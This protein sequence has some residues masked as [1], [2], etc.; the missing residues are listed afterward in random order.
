[1][2]EKKYLAFDLGAES[3]RAVIGF[4]NGKSLRLEVLH[5]FKNEPQMLG[6]TLYWDILSLFKEMKNSLK[7]FKS[8]Y[9]NNLESIGVDTWG[10]DFGLIGKDGNLLSNPV[11]YRD[12]RTNGILKEAFKQVSKYEIYKK[13]GIQVMQINTLYQLLSLVITDSPLL[14]VS[15]KFLMIPDLFNYFFT[16]EKL[17]EWTDATTTQMF[18]PDKKTWAKDLLRKMKIPTHIMPDVIFPGIKIGNLLKSISNETSLTNVK[19]C[20]PASHDT[21][22]AVVSVPSTYNENWAYLSSGTWSLLGVEIKEPIINKESYELNFTNEGG[23]FGTYRFLKN[24]MGLWLLQRCR[25]EWQE[26][27]SEE[28]SYKKLVNLAKKAKRLRS[29]IDPNHDSFLNPPNMT[30]A[31][32]NYCNYTNQPVPYDMALVVRCIFESLSFTY[33][34]VIDDLNK[35]TKRKIRVLHIVGGGVQ[36]KLLCQFT[37]NAATMPV[38]AGPIEATAIGNILMQ[39]V[40]ECEI[41][42]LIDARNI[43]KDSFDN[44]IYEPQD[45][46]QWEE[47]YQRF[48]TVQ[49]KL[50]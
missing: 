1:M 34:K 43:V 32:K 33:K 2:K 46:S 5:R 36:N 30:M 44:V 37:A 18:S 28:I 11:H 13:T 20:A 7:M 48:L 27:K 23:A 12:K 15:K 16:G 39:M 35:L 31:I 38:I 42:T 8:K 3:G 17:C 4:F 49:G 14:K 22:S 9:G 10:V 47:G 24:I 29:F 19:V 50:K 40:A 45:E 41:S 25:K 6:D 21:G 26:E